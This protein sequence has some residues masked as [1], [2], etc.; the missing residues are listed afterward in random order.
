MNLL[1]IEINECERLTFL[2]VWC[3]SLDLEQSPKVSVLMVLSRVLLG[4]GGTWRG[5]A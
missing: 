2:P 5:G 1:K 4:S 3:H